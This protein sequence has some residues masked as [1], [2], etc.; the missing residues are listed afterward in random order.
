MYLAKKQPSVRPFSAS[1]WYKPNIQSG[2]CVRSLFCHKLC[3]CVQGL[4]RLHNEML[5]PVGIRITENSPS[6]EGR[7]F[8]RFLQCQNKILITQLCLILN[9]LDVWAD[10]VLLCRENSM[11]IAGHRMPNFGL[12][13][14]DT[15]TNSS[16]GHNTCQRYCLIQKQCDL[17]CVC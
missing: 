14:Y 12:L 3:V 11:L 16:L 9:S 6:E 17:I 15:K 4:A 8:D 13:Y 5:R 2:D 1:S 7:A 10:S